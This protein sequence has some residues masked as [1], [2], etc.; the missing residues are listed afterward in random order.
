MLKVGPLTNRH[1]VTHVTELRATMP[2]GVELVADAWHPEGEG[3]WP[4]LLQRLPY[5]RTV[6]SSV[7]LPH[8]VHLARRGYAVVVQDVRGRGSSDGTFEPFVHEADDGAATVEW[9]ARL[10]F[11]DGQVGMYGFSYQGLATLLAAGRRPPSLKAIAPVMCAADPYEGWTYEGGCLQW[12]FVPF[13]ADLLTGRGTGYDLAALPTAGA[14]GED[15]PEWFRQWLDHRTP[16]AWWAA[17]SPDLDAIDV[18][19]LYIGG[20]QDTFRSSMGRLLDR[21]GAEAVLGPWAHMPWRDPGPAHERFI[22]FFD[23]VLRG[24]GA[25]PPRVTYFTAG[26]G[27]QDAPA[28]PP[29]TVEVHRWTGTSDGDA[30]SRHGDGRLVPGAADPGPADILAAEP[31]VPVPGTLEPAT[32]ET[33]TEDRRDVLCYTSAELERPL[34]LTGAATVEVGSRADVATHD[35]IASLTDVAPDG[36]ST[37]LCTGAVR[38]PASGTSIGRVTTVELAPISHC[39]PAGHR[40]RLDL[41]ASRFPAFD[42]NPQHPTVEPHRATR[43]DCRVALIE[44]HAVEV[45][46]PVN[47][48]SG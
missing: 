37:R 32:D 2:D 38:Q 19:A 47:V 3:P 6:A 45:H 31:L 17:R 16:D 9:A 12:T 39:L 8:P 23:R 41:S 30:A 33:A 14:L 20:W 24:V 43:D 15:P 36:T 11:A 13:W 29:P 46:L 10:P 35:V 5:G 18:P 26:V 48:M 44:V 25:P 27:W 42:R 34:V 28:W 1:N 40:L 22:G 4:V 21:L 7:V